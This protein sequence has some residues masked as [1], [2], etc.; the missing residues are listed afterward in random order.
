MSSK[1]IIFWSLSLNSRLS[2]FI[3]SYYNSDTMSVRSKIRLFLF[4]IVLTFPE[5]YPG[6]SPRITIPVRIRDA[7]HQH[8]LFQKEY[9]QLLINGREREIVRF[10]YFEKSM[11]ILPELRRHFI[12]SFQIQ[13]FN[14]NVR[15][16]IAYIITEILHPGDHLIL[17]SPLGIYQLKIPENKANLLSKCNSILTRDFLK[18]L[19][20]RNSARKFL[21]NKLRKLKKV[22]RR[23][24]SYSGPYIGSITFLNTYPTEFNNYKNRYLILDP[25]VFQKINNLLI[26]AEGEKWWIHMHDHETFDIFFQTG[27]IINDINQYVTTTNWRNQG[28]PKA[29]TSKLNQLEQLLFLKESFSRQQIIDSLLKGNIGLSVLM[30]SQI[31][32]VPSHTYSVVISDLVRVFKD[33][34]QISGGI[35]LNASKP[36]QEMKRFK[37]HVDCYHEVDFYF[38]GKI[39]PKTITLNSLIR[40]NI[41]T[42]YPRAFSVQDL[43]TLIEFHSQKKVS[44][45][46]FSRIRNLL[47]FKIHSFQINSL[48]ES[49]QHY[50][51]LKVIVS[52]ANQKH[53]IVFSSDKILRASE[54]KL[55]ISM[56]LPENLEGN[57]LLDIRVIDLLANHQARLSQQIYLN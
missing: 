34:S 3:Q 15:S 31:G 7:T 27:D 50:G 37:N 32:N 54:E 56:P 24:Q 46:G 36:S 49:K 25:S 22:Y 44:I 12:L 11:G 6:D 38:D 52:L 20:V 48:H 42:A 26:S 51:L 17:V 40:K 21:I 41:T 1:T 10:E 45:T 35:I 55:D 39:Q 13:E 43:L 5:L 8:S 29:I 16:R 23:P 4:V 28:L 14:R 19:Q 47:S 2:F 57:Y 33:I 9:F 53:T 30:F 18:H